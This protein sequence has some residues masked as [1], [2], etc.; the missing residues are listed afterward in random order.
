MATTTKRTNRRTAAGIRVAG[1][2]ILIGV[3]VAVLVRPLFSGDDSYTPPPTPG[4]RAPVNVGE[5][6]PDFTLLN[7]KGESVSL[8][9]F[10]GKPTIL[11]F[12][13]TFG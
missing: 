1:G 5:T 6:A 2:I 4:D 8:R 9:D 11:V 10:R 13:R 12:F 3:L 7:A